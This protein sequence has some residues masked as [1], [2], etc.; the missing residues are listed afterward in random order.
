MTMVRHALSPYFSTPSISA[1]ICS[2]VQRVLRLGVRAPAVAVV[3]AADARASSTMGMLS[4]SSGTCNSTAKHGIAH[5]RQRM[6]WTFYLPKRC[7][8]TAAG[9]SCR[10]HCACACRGAAQHSPAC[11]SLCPYCGKRCAAWCL[12]STARNHWQTHMRN[13]MAVEPR[14]IFVLVSKP[15]PQHSHSHGS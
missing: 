2:V 11:D 12:R 13:Q 14:L 10:S 5:R 3:Y 9:I 8:Q 7:W 6:S 4:S 1:S 15:H